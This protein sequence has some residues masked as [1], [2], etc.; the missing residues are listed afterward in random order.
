MRSRRDAEENRNCL[1]TSVT[2][3]RRKQRKWPSIVS[4]STRAVRLMR[5]FK[6][7]DKPPNL[8]NCKSQERKL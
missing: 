2:T 4:H 7:G 5:S 1:D 6:L 8:Q 3:M